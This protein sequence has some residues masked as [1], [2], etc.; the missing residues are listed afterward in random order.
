MCVEFIEVL[1]YITVLTV[2]IHLFKHLISFLQILLPFTRDTEV[3]KHFS[4]NS[5]S[6]PKSY[7]RGKL[8]DENFAVLYPPNGVIPFHGFAMYGRYGVFN[9]W[10]SDSTFE[11]SAHLPV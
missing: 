11:C 1:P 7:I 5:A 2:F 3:L 9:F 4:H 6:P 8:G 10:I